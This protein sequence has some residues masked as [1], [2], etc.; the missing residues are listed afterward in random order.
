MYV[1]EEFSTQ[2]KIWHGHYRFG[3]KSPVFWLTG[4][5]IYNRRVVNEDSVI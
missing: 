2:R 1:V 5:T 4:I 3:I